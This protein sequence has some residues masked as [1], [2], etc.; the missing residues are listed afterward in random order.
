MQGFGDLPPPPELLATLGCACSEEDAG[1][2][3]GSRARG[4]QMA[5]GALVALT[6]KA[7]RWARQTSQGLQEAPRAGLWLSGPSG[8]DLHL[9]FVFSFTPHHSPCLCS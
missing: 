8:L 4:S 3:S 5:L 2:S 6:Q 1:S 9:H 7:V